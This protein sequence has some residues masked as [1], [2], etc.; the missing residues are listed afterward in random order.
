MKLSSIALT[1]CAT[2]TV[3]SISGCTA[4]GTEYPTFNQTTNPLEYLMQY[5]EADELS[6]IDPYLGMSYL[7]LSDHR[8][9]KDYQDHSYWKRTW[10]S[11]TDEPTF[12]DE[13][14]RVCEVNGGA[15]QDS[16]WCLNVKNKKPIFYVQS[17]IRS[18][19]TAGGGISAE[20]IFP[21]RGTLA[22]D[23]AWQQFVVTFNEAKKREAEEQERAEK[24]K[25]KS[26][27][28]ALQQRKL[29]TAKVLK[30]RPGQTLCRYTPAS[31]G[32]NYSLQRARLVKVVSDELIVV[33]FPNMNGDV[34]A[35]QI[36]RTERAWDWYVCKA[37][38]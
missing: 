36:K 32:G 34:W 14:A 28:D 23:P 3:F 25:N 33:E 8:V 26:E 10:C 12:H 24:A 7:G 13:V 22:S 15:L 18:I 5:A 35:P 19:C 27:Q 17:K 11:K 1:L 9:I 16:G 31:M 4:V 38:R 21:K 37:Q 20:G 30:A 2:A 6:L 29:N